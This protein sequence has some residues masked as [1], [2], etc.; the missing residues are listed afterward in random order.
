M[1]KT[2]TVLS[3]TTYSVPAESV[4]EALDKF[5]DNSEDVSE[6][7]AETTATEDKPYFDLTKFLNDR[8]TDLRA[9]LASTDENDSLC[10]YLEGCIDAYEIVLATQEN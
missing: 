5:F 8:L 3:G 6:I 7:E 1:A 2:F 4:E 10:D 9:A